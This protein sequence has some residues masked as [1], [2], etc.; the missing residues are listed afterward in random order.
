[1]TETALTTTSADQNSALVPLMDK[2]REFVAQA[3]AENTLRAYRTDWAHFA[4]WCAAH[5]LDTLPA[6]PETIALYIADLA[7]AAKTSTITRRLAAIA[8]A[9][10]AKGLESPCSMK[11]ALVK[12]VLD[13][14][15][16]TKG[17]A[18]T[19]KAA[20]LTEDLRKLIAVLPDSLLGKRDAALLLVAFAGG[21]RRSELVALC[22]ADVAFCEDG[23][24]VTLRRSKTDQEGHGR[25]IGIPYGSD[26]RTCPVRSLRRWLDAAGIS[27]GPLFRYVDKHGHIAATAL[28]P[29]VVWKVVKR[30]CTAAGLDAAQFG[31]HSLRA[32]LA[33]QAAING[34]S[35]RAIMRQTGHKSTAM[36]R[37]Y[38]R[39]ADLFRENAATKLGL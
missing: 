31:A 11:H 21:F 5:G 32:G 29:Q 28:T 38:I 20:L 7:A 26:P 16:R 24:R 36:V 18:Q 19:G 25:V 3:K 12:E 39:D 23:L 33:T 34:A 9:H 6:A 8:K 10:Q 30:Y 14:V 1:M 13:G 2:A 35:E 17:T 22:A 15:K 4:A 37:R 27:E